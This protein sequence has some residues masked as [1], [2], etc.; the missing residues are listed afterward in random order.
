M[1]ESS[2]SERE[3]RRQKI[4]LKLWELPKNENSKQGKQSA[5]VGVKAVNAEETDKLARKTLAI[6]ATLKSYR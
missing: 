1:R 6:L 2:K 3:D 4:Q 5:D